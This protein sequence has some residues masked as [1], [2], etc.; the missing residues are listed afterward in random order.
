MNP[1]AGFEE[2]ILSVEIDW[3]LIRKI[4]KNSNYV[5]DDDLY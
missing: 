2:I 4:E 5:D 1:S 3:V